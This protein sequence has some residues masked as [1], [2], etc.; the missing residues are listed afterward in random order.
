MTDKEGH[1]QYV[2]PAFEKATGY[3]KEEVFGKN[4]RI[5]K[6]GH[7]N[8]PFYK[9]MWGTFTT[10]R[11][12]RG[13]LINRK[14]DDTLY[15]VEAS[16]SPVWDGK[17]NIINYVAVERDMTERIKLERQLHH[18]QKMEAIGTLA[19][20]I[21]HDFNNILGAIIGFTE[22]TLDNLPESSINYR[23][24]DRVLKASHRAKELAGQIL[25]F[26]RKGE[27]EKKP[28]QVSLIVK[29]TLFL[30]RASLP[31]TIKVHQNI[32]GRPGLI[33]ADSTQIHQVLMNLCTNAAQAM[34]EEG[35]R[36]EVILEDMEIGPEFLYGDLQP[37]PYLKLTVSDTGCGMDQVTMERIFEPY[38]TTKK[39]GEGTGLGLAVVHGIVKSHGGEITVYSEPGR[40][41][42]FQV[43]FPRIKSYPTGKLEL[44]P[45]VSGGEERI[46][47][48]DDEKDLVDAGYQTLARL[49]Y[50][51]TATTSSKEALNVFRKNPGKFDL[52]IT[53][54]TMPEITGCELS[55]KL[56]AIR[57]DIPVILCTGLSGILR[58]EEIL[59][60]GIR[61]FISKPF[62]K[63][64]IAKA[65]RNILDEKLIKREGSEEERKYF[66]P[67][68]I[69]EKV[70]ILIVDDNS[71]NQQN[72]QSYFK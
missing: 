20:G 18:A 17:G 53:D 59:A 55:K 12:W 69:K 9:D 39:V 61:E 24:L 63:K 37:G 26:S 7:H 21:A 64:T 27:Q 57:P 16:I 28:V 23:N 25:A 48:I 5:L 41:T 34:M 68:E 10:G 43:Y 50:K 65:L 47:F 72:I 60:A 42:T 19:G 44:S 71:L 67:E 15:E 3:M 31:A 36:L 29:D 56:I 33:L 54:Q 70:H 40:G 32:K 6:S 38:F 13:H 49:G 8:E 1:I 62:T 45:T 51:V 14:K 30:L 52:V 46:L 35:G 58:P 4:I 66:I 11:T 2:N 22:L